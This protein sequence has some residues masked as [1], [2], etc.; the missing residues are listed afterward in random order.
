MNELVNFARQTLEQQHAAPLIQATGQAADWLVR[1][2]DL[3]Q[4]R[5]GLLQDD[6]RA[7]P[8]LSAL[9]D[10][11]RCYKAQDLDGFTKGAAGARRLMCFVPGATIRWQGIANQRFMILG[12]A[13]VEYVHHDDGKLYVFVVWQ[14]IER[15]VSETSIMQIERP[16]R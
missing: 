6:P 10:C 16:T 15:W 14:G 11:D 3:T 4:V 2:R 8:V 1:W 5:D 7:N 13:T 12:P 9:S